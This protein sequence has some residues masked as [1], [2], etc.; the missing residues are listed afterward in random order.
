M[1]NYAQ[2]DKPI[3]EGLAVGLGIRAR[4][5]KAEPPTRGSTGGVSLSDQL[6]GSDV[7]PMSAEDLTNPTAEYFGWSDLMDRATAGSRP[8]SKAEVTRGYRKL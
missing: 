8:F 4:K 3:T 2:G 1:T 5:K 7:T 6:R